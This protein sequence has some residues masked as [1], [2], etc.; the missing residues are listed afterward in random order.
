MVGK[1]KHRVKKDKHKQSLG[2][3]IDDPLQPSTSRVRVKFMMIY[4]AT[5][6][7]CI[8]AQV[9]VAVNCSPCISRHRLPDR[10]GVS[11]FPVCAQDRPEKR[12]RAAEEETEE[13]NWSRRGFC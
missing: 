9:Q 10:Q 2:E 5:A 7:L 12:K 4:C 6:L 11:T 1:G 3:Q 13:V 8:R